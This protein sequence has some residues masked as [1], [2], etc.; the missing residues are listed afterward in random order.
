MSS[1]T[2]TARY[3]IGAVAR[4][5]GLS[6]HVLRMWELRYRAIVPDRSGGRHRRY[7]ERDIRR[8][9]LL[10]T[11]QQ[12]G[13]AI[14]E[15]A[16]L[17]DAEIIR[18]V[19]H[20]TAGASAVPLARQMQDCE[21]AI[22]ALDPWR[23]TATLHRAV[24]NYG[25]VAVVEHLIAPVMRRIGAR[26]SSGDLEPHHEH[27]ATT[28]FRAFLDAA[29][30]MQRLSVEAPM[31][32]AGTAS[33]EHHELGILAAAVVAAGEG[34][35]VVYLGADVPAAGIVATA[36][37]HRPGAVLISMTRCPPPPAVLHDLRVVVGSIESGTIVLC[38]GAGADAARPAI[39]STGAIVAGLD[40]VRA[41]L[42]LRY[43][44]QHPV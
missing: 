27:L 23:L 9:Q 40:G 43:T 15:V 13:L 35:R 34:W 2:E 8:V 7:S 18:L 26:W 16:G 1:R 5:T 10:R 12:R 42:R 14:G 30:G 39:E 17:T 24:M 44:V 31:A 36:A 38:G 37:A 32:V 4:R 33:G 22:S 28:T 25:Y 19:Y 29:L 20:G 41:T 3:P 6:E 21:Q 11:A